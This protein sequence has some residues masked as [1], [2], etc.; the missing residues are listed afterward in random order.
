ME[1]PARSPSELTEHTPRLEARPQ[2]REGLAR[3]GP[4]LFAFPRDTPQYN[5]EC[6]HGLIF[7]LFY[8]FPSVHH[9][10]IVGR[11]MQ[12]QHWHPKASQSP[13]CPS[14]H[15]SGTWG[16]PLAPSS[17][18]LTPRGSSA[19]TSTHR[20]RDPGDPCWAR[21]TPSSVCTRTHHPC[22][23]QPPEMPESAVETN[24]NFYLTGT[25]G[26][27]RLQLG[28]DS[29]PRQPKTLMTTR[30]LGWPPEECVGLGAALNHSP[31]QMLLHIKR[32]DP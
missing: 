30:A 18:H 8:F 23:S 19:S 13:Q 2:A 11:D 4:C 17:Q 22:T 14:E 16:E 32:A 15:T 28:K 3:A 24:P 1:D 29:Q 6:P 27:S 26:Q 9:C 25:P 5:C 20:W 10:F 31:I 12:I 21:F 7:F